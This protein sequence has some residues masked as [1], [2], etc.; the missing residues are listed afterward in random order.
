MWQRGIAHLL[1]DR[2]VG[3]HAF[4][5]GPGR[6]RWARQIIEVE[7]LG[8][9][10][11]RGDRFAGRAGQQH[12]VTRAHQADRTV[13]IPD[14]GEGFVHRPATAGLL[15]V[16]HKAEATGFNPPGGLVRCK[17]GW[18]LLRGGDLFELITQVDAFDGGDRCGGNRGD[19]GTSLPA[20]DR[21]PCRRGTH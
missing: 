19:L 11:Q 5:E 6:Q 1:I 20:F 4:D 14:N 10:L 13:T 15:V 21:R 18:R 3:F 7:P 16:V 8:W 9:E 17:P 12:D 2:A